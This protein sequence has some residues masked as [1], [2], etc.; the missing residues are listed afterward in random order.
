MRLRVASTRRA[1]PQ[2]VE[3][4]R[5]VFVLY[6][7]PNAADGSVVTTSARADAIR[8]RLRQVQP[9]MSLVGP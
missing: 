7:V 9:Q 6:Q 5:A 4:C 1:N 8:E 2:D 3:E